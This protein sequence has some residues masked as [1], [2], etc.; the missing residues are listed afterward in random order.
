M[1][2]ES[3]HHRWLVVD[4]DATM[5]ELTTEVLR[6]VPG[7]EV[8]A[9][10]D[11]RTALDVFFADPETFELVV[12][13]FNMPGLDGIEFAQAV[14]ARAPQLKVLM[15]TGSDL[16]GASAGCG[17]LQ[18]LLPKPFAPAALL[19]AVRSVLG[20]VPPIICLARDSSG[21]WRKSVCRPIPSELSQLSTINS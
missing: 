17:E 7:S 6:G 11:S 1:K 9:C 21:A 18:V 15:V 13:D 8:V 19:A 5:L 12:T 14:H 4:D 16:N 20:P 2:T 3:N 10:N